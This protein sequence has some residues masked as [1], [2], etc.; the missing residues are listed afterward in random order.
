MPSWLVLGQL[1]QHTSTYDSE[2]I[3]FLG[4]AGEVG[5]HGHIQTKMQL[6]AQDVNATCNQNL[7]VNCIDVMYVPYPPITK[8][9]ILYTVAQSILSYNCEILT[10]DYRFKKKLLNTEMDFSEALQ[11]HPK[12]YKQEVK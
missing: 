3:S 1:Q 4:A 11:E 12:C 5:F 8:K 9:L 7:F 6:Y 10:V 2:K